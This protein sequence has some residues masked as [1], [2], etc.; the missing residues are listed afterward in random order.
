MNFLKKYTLILSLIFVSSIASFGQYGN[1]WIDFNKT[2]YKFQSD[3][4]GLHRISYQALSESDIP[5]VGAD[6]KLITAGEEIPIYVTTNGTF[7]SDDFIEF[8]GT[9]NDGAFDTQLYEDP[10]YQPQ[11]EFSLFDDTRTYFLVSDSSQPNLR[12]EGEQNDVS[13]FGTPE[14]YF[15]HESIL[16]PT[17]TFHFGEP[18]N[19]YEPSH[20]ETH[21]HYPSTFDKGEGFVS[22]VIADMTDLLPTGENHGVN[23]KLNNE[24]LYETASI[25]AVVN[26][27]MVG[28]S[29]K[30]NTSNNQHFSIEIGDELLE[31]DYFTG[32]DIKNYEFNVPLSLLNTELDFF[33]EVSTQFN[34]KGYDGIDNGIEYNTKVSVCKASLVYPR[35]FN[36]E[37]HSSFLFNLEL[38][39]TKYF[40]IDNFDNAGAAVLYD[41][42]ANKRIIPTVENDH[43]K[44][45]LN[46]DGQAAHKLFIANEDLAI[47]INSLRPK[48]FRD[49]TNP[50]YQ[51]NYIILTTSALI[52]G[53]TELLAD[54][55]QDYKNYRSSETGGSFDVSVVWIN[56]LYDQFAQGIQQHPLAIKNFVDFAMDN[57]SNTPEYLNILGKGLRYEKSRFD[58][59]LAE[60]SLIPSYGFTASDN[61]FGIRNRMETPQL[62]I[63]RVPVKS[64]EEIGVDLDKII[65]H[66]STR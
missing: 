45:V 16:L 57:W 1:E 25:D 23:F 20:D 46:A 10:F 30:E 55:V 66:E 28:R 29:H 7:G 37:G 54:Y 24:Q 40:Q 32:F 22:S 60:V 6:F 27:K 58:L 44:F 14:P 49:F 63:G 2:Y 18:L 65:A 12:F 26:F 13:N 50:V 52:P 61:Y 43:H 41:L 53:P 8:Y 11:V 19:I 42:T 59:S 39:S 35:N 9:K 48:Q 3:E 36:L 38:P 62:A 4:T 33:N 17:N 47:E 51:G 15:L 21:Y 34:I 5:L 64:R 56:E 31:E